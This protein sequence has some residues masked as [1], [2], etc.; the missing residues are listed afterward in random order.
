M[1]DKDKEEQ[2]VKDTEKNVLE[3]MHKIV[4]ARL[5]DEKRSE[6]ESES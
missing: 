3:G 5:D 1:E 4:D 6:R 2:I